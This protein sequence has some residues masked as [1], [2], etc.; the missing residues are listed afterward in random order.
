MCDLLPIGTPVIFTNDYG[1]VFDR[2]Y[3]ISGYVSEDDDLY[4]WG[5]RYF[6]TGTDAPWMPGSEVQWYR[7]DKVF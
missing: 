1:I 6:L 5:H 3:V 7:V 4:K 2:G